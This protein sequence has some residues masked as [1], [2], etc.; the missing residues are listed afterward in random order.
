MLELHFSNCFWKKA[1]AIANFTI[2]SLQTDVVM[3]MINGFQKHKK[4]IS[5]LFGYL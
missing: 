1:K 4:R 3:K 5:L 2:Q